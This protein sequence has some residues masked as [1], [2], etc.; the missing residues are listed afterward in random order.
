MRVG[1]RRNRVQIH[2]H[3]GKGGLQGAKR[4]SGRRLQILARVGRHLAQ[5]ALAKGAQR[6]LGGPLAGLLAVI[7]SGAL[8]N[9]LSLAQAVIITMIVIEVVVVAT[10]AIER[11]VPL[12]GWTLPGAM[13]CG[14]LQILM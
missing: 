5:I 14:A 12:R 13:T 2:G 10:G 9:N 6:D 7:S 8:T 3:V 1:V 4:R 11:P